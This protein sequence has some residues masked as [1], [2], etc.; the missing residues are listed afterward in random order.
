MHKTKFILASVLLFAFACVGAHA[1]DDK[2]IRSIAPEA[3]EKLLQ[4]M[5]VEFKKSSSKKGD[6]HYFDFTRNG[7]KVRLTQYS[8]EDM[9]LDCVFRGAPI[10]KVNQW[11]TYTRLSRASYHKD[12]S[13]E[14]CIL[15]YGLDLSGGVSTGAVKQ[16]ITRFDEELKKFDKFLGNANDDIV[17]ADVSDEK[18]EN[19]LKTMA[20]NYQK[21][22]NNA[23]VMMF[24]FEMSSF[25]IRL[26]NFGGKDLMMDAHFRKIP[27]EVANRYNLNRKFVRVVNYKSK[28]TEYTALEANLDCEAGVTEGALRHWIVSFGEDARH[29]SDFTKKLAAADK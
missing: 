21:K 24:D 16:L 23:G 29:F 4:D 27:L 17:I 15:E 28:D 20:I 8:P 26:Y 19:V 11:N 13:G 14:F 6:E 5:K 3:T 1:Q 7:Y 22:K 10:E 12:A 2:V 18:V 9:M 25:K